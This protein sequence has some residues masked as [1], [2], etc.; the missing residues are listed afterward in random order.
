MLIEQKRRV[1]RGI[2]ISFFTLVLVYVTLAPQITKIPLGDGSDVRIRKAPFLRAIFSEAHS[3]I[4]YSPKG[5]NAGE[6]VLWQSLFDGS[7]TV[8]AAR[9]TN[10]LLCLY[11]Y[12]VDFRLFKINTEKA[13]S[14]MALDDDLKSVL[15]TSS[16]EIQ[17]GDFTDWQQMLDYLLKTPPALFAKQSVSVGTR[18]NQ[19][20]EAIVKR[21]ARQG[22]RPDSK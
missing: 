21:L 18:F 7:V 2:I 8:I 6:I 5:K 1:A 13:F 15:F 12:D 10:V 17:N 4:A 20:P 3:D 11:D 22:I 14:P 9:E 19:T 16:W